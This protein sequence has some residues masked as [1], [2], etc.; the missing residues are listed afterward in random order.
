MQLVRKL[1]FIAFHRIQLRHCEIS[2]SGAAAQYVRR[3]T[4]KFSWICQKNLRENGG[5]KKSVKL[6][7]QPW[8]LKKKNVIDVQLRLFMLWIAKK[9]KFLPSTSSKSDHLIRGIKQCLNQMDMSIVTWMC[10]KMSHF[11]V[12]I[13]KKQQF[14]GAKF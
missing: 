9:V 12:R 6:Q 13:F 8:I 4:F 1:K 11:L 2:G 5:V 10:L 3:W 14:F 7:Q